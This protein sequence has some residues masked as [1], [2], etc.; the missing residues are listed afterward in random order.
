MCEL[1]HILF[2]KSAMVE[3]E[4]AADITQTTKIALPLE[5]QLITMRKS[6][7]DSKR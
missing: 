6:M 5:V 3:V 2:K 7:H 1:R 4:V